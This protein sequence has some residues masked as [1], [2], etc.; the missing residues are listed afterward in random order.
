LLSEQP[1]FT[2]LD[3]GLGDGTDG[4][5]LLK[6]LKGKLPAKSKIFVFSG[7]TEHKQQCLD[8][9]ADEFISK[10]VTMK[11]LTEILIKHARV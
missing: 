1:D 5:D 9:G 11:E 6:K 4:L 10:R 7:Y 2:L 3:L 8:E